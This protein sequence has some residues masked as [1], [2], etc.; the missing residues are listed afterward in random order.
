MKQ[1]T[2]T[3]TYKL[4][5]QVRQV[6]SEQQKTTQSDRAPVKEAQEAKTAAHTVKPVKSS[7]P[8][9]QHDLTSA[10]LPSQ[11]L[12]V[13]NKAVLEPSNITSASAPP[14]KQTQ[15]APALTTAP[16]VPFTESE[17]SSTFPPSGSRMQQRRNQPQQ[18]NQRMG[19]TNNNR[20][21]KPTNRTQNNT[22]DSSKVMDEFNF[23]ESNARFDKSKV[24]D[25]VAVK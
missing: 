16:Q 25:E 4:Q 14:V 5:G 13:D 11:S 18:Q 12:P 19:P 8:P 20:G 7:T 6:G 22:R 9:A 15:T 2:R 23:T 17:A 24:Y 3:L 1:K 10:P 21:R